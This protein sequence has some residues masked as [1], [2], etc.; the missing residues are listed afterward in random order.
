MEERESIYCHSQLDSLSRT[1]TLVISTMHWFI[2]SKNWFNEGG[3]VE[4]MRMMEVMIVRHT[5]SSVDVGE[6]LAVDSS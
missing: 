1:Q 2:G 4:R 6:C 5:S 3:A